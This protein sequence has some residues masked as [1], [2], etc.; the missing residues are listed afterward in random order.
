MHNQ[1]GLCIVDEVQIG[2]GRVGTHFWG[3][4]QQ[5][6]SPDIVILGKPMANG[7]PIGAV[8][9]TDAVAKSFETGMEFFSSFGGNPVS[10]AIGTAVLDV[11]EQEGLQERA[12][13]VGTYFISELWNLQEKHSVIA[14]IRGSGM[15][16]GIDI[17]KEDRTP[18]TELAQFLKNG[19]KERHIL[20]GTDGPADNVIKIKPPL[21]FNK[22]NVDTVI[23]ELSDLLKK[24]P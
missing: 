1:G 7:H 2:F 8:V 15:F 17:A 6:V 18:N 4:Q 10:C 3:F 14:D 22:R 19:M 20:V 24:K 9:T 13:E 16:L 23:S 21:S 5:E 11:I 12:L